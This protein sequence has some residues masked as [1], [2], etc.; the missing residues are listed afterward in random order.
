MPGMTS[1]SHPLRINSVSAASAGGC[2]GLTLCPG[3]KQRGALSGTW[4]RDLNL[5]L[6]AIKEYG[7]AALVSLMEESD[8]ASV[9]VPV[10]ILASTA[11]KLGLEWHHLPIRDVQAPD[12]A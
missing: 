7:A 5:D 8:L 10:N 1:E 11:A 9:Q 12:A 6:T 4:H 3:K 2:I